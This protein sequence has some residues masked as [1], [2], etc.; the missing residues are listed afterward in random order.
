MIVAF[1]G[2]TKRW[3]IWLTKLPDENAADVGEEY[4][5]LLS[6]NLGGKLELKRDGRIGGRFFF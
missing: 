3:L 4:L 2:E 6:W 5:Q 1:Q